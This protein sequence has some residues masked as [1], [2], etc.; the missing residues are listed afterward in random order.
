MIS[1]LEKTLYS[2][3][4]RTKSIDNVRKS[5]QDLEKKQAS[6]FNYSGVADMR[7]KG[8]YEEYIDLIQTSHQIDSLNVS[9]PMLEQRIGY[10]I[11]VIAQ[12]VKLASD[13]QGKAM[14]FNSLTEHINIK[15]IAE[16]SLELLAFKLNT[17][18]GRGYIF[19]GQNSDLSPIKDIKSFVEQSNFLGDNPTRNYTNIISSDDIK[20]IG[21]NRE[22]N[23]NLDATAL[24]FQKLIA[25]LHLMKDMK[26]GSEDDQTKTVK[27]FKDAIKEFHNIETDIN[28]KQKILADATKGIQ[29]VRENIVE[30]LSDYK[31]DIPDIIAQRTE[32]ETSLNF[33]INALSNTFK[34]PTLLDYMRG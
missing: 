1:S 30:S 17:T 12:V 11:D 28:Y 33:A 27:M 29:D 25:A 10:K 3:L 24:G 9:N 5:M 14:E 15:E 32:L 20:I 8:V 13:V 7:Q 34:A 16:Q 31:S 26:P 18:D 21:L 19:G 6:N 4:Y 2:G 23:E 22:L